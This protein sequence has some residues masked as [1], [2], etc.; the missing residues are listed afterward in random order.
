[1]LNCIMQFVMFYIHFQPISCC[2]CL[3]QR[4]V[5]CDGNLF[6]L[7]FSGLDVHKKKPCNLWCGGMCHQWTDLNQNQEFLKCYYFVDTQLFFFF[8][9]TIPNFFYKVF[10]NLSVVLLSP[11]IQS[12]NVESLQDCG[13][14]PVPSSPDPTLCDW[15]PGDPVLW[16]LWA[17]HRKR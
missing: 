4:G 8:T 17:G 1:M 10:P 12:W 11:V 13:L 6:Q 9:E 5:L 16:S 14:R 2:S 3:G 7:H 15:T